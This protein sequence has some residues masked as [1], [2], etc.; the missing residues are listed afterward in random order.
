ME[1]RIRRIKT[2]HII[3]AVMCLMYFISY[4]DRVN[5]AVAG[6]LIRHEMGLTTV[7]LGL[8]FSAF[9]YPYAA[10]QIVGGWLADK[11][12][13]KLVLTVLSLI[14]GV[15]TLATGFAGSVTMLVLMRF[16]LGIGEGG[17]FPTA[18]RAFT[19]WMPVAERG[20]AQGITH[21]FAR[22]GGAVTPPLVLAV[23][24][25]GG[26]RDAFILL[27]I[28]SLAWTV[29]YLFVFTNSPEQNRRITPEE[30]TEIGY[31][32][33]DCD[34][35]KHAATPWRKLIRRMWLV[36]FVDF[37][38][39]WL[40]WVYL[41]WLPSY[42]RE[43]RGFD[44]KQLAL[45]TALPLLAGV[46]GDTLGGVVSDKL[47]KITGRLRFARCAVLVVGM[48]GSLVFLVPMV[49]ATNPL[50]A[51]W[52]LSASFFFLEITNPVL[53]TLPL[54]IAGKYAGTA[55]GMMNTGFGV[56]GMI[57]PVVFGYLIEKTGSYNVPFT[58]SAGLLAVGVLASL[59]IDTSKTVE[60]DEERE[61]AVGVPLDGMPAFLHAGPAVRLERH[62]L[63]RPLRWWK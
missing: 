32:A 48:G 45:F 58:I 5:I 41:T 23:V 57:S 21:S 34:R 11:F 4:I 2:R 46:V 7:Q 53:W 20:F 17:A 50:T 49:S 39:G 27:G 44:L 24:A 9:A 19:Y 38:Y 13:P 22:L 31:R 18:T 30:T 56:A 33:G 37:C 25:T 36:T 61:R 28:A 60:A 26:W 55:G 43:S 35:A 16:A 54:D 3:L 15:A 63:R 29:L 10:M 6:P 52:F 1:T 62:H 8:V 42:L 14:W 40:L 47:F 59:F 12:G 51:V